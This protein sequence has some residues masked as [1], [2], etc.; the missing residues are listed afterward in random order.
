MSMM[1]AQ[2]AG[3][4]LA[5]KVEFL[6]NKYKLPAEDNMLMALNSK[7]INTDL[8]YPRIRFRLKLDGTSKEFYAGVPKKENTPF[9]VSEREGL[10]LLDGNRLGTVRSAENDTCDTIYMRRGG[11]V[12]NL[13]SNS[14]SMCKGCRFCF[15]A[16]TP[17]DR[18]RLLK[19]PEIEE[20]V[21][22]FLSKSG[23]E[24]LSHL[25]QVAIVT[26]CFGG[27]QAVVDH[28]MAA[29]EVL[30]KHGF[31][32]ELLYL[33]AQL[34]SPE[35]FKTLKRNV[36]NFAFVMA[37]ECFERREIL[38]NKIKSSLG[39]EKIRDILAHSRELGFPTTVTYIV[40]L[41]SLEEMEKGFERIRDV[42]TRFPITNIFQ[43][44]KAN[45]EPLL[46]DEARELDYYLDAR[47]VFERMF[48]DTA[49]RPRSW[50]NYRSL[51][52]F[53]FSGEE[54]HGP[55]I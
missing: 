21:H 48:S 18:K 33:G 22:D 26:G 17:N 39:A 8:P 20:F 30:S 35:S 16:Q 53:K 28:L 12:L 25:H 13:N 44:H 3:S 4:P 45:Q 2:T 15:D 42:L 6:A 55:T 32:G 7:G 34:R 52:Y 9:F 10:L 40:G 11:T 27:E 19:A 1:F 46:R 54:M 50:E 41:D 43:P 36:G 29:Y 14:R 38:L 24:D 51:W 37:L 49:L 47:L 23:R 5:R 31:Q